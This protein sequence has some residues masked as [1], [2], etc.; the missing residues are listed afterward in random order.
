MMGDTLQR[1]REL[2]RVGE[3][4]IS[5]HGYDELVVYGISA[6]EIAEGVPDALL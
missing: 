1:I 5:E 4:K 2:V 6:R 3:V